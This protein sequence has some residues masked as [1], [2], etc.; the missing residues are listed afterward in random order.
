MLYSLVGVLTEQLM[1]NDGMAGEDTDHGENCF[2][3][4]R[5]IIISTNIENRRSAAP[6]QGKS[7]I[8]NLLRD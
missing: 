8:S 4:R 6:N 2:Q 3:S 1:S 5:I 7:K